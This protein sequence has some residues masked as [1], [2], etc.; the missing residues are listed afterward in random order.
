MKANLVTDNISL[1]EAFGKALVKL[2]EKQEFYLVDCDVAGGTGTHHFRDAYPDR[3]IQVGIAEQNGACIAAGL[4]ATTN[5]PVF[6]T[7]F[8]I[9]AMR[10]WEQIRLSIAYSNRN[11]KIVA[12]HPGL[13]VGPDGASAQCLE[14]LACMQA[15]PNMTVIS[16]C[17]VRETELATEA[18]LNHWGPVYMRTG[19]S[20]I[21]C[22]IYSNNYNDFQIGQG[23]Y[24][25]RGRDI[26]IIACGVMTH[27]ALLAANI[28][29]DMGF[30]ANVVNMSTIKPIDKDIIID[31]AKTTRGIVVCEDHN[32]IGGL[33]SAV[34]R[35]VTNNRPCPVEFVGVPD[36]FGQSGE[37]DELAQEYGLTESKIVSLARL[38][39]EKSL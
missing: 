8:A 34:A 15:I 27:R 35:V 29:E 3:F 12:S 28:L 14:D 39:M 13:D 37:A 25:R 33:G 31:C 32:I 30:S 18:I 9:F 1:R 22:E 24:L 26:S 20:P 36:V 16:P 19:R 6:F 11:V 21:D 2:A 17:D 23:K 7:T 5:L 10:A 4:N 38:V